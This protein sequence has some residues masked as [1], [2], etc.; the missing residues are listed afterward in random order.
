[1]TS[2]ANIK[3]APCGQASP[4]VL[5]SSFPSTVQHISLESHILVSFIVLPEN[6]S[7][8]FARFTPSHSLQSHQDIDLARRQVFESNS[9]R[10]LEDSF[11]TY[12]QI[13]KDAQALWVFGI[14]SD[15]GGCD[16]RNSSIAERLQALDLHGL[17]RTELD[18]FH[19]SDIY[20]CCTSCSLQRKPCPTCLQLSTPGSPFSSSSSCQTQ[21]PCDNTPS[22]EPTPSLSPAAGHISISAPPSIACNIPRKPLR[23]PYTFF[24]GAVRDRVIHDICERACTNGKVVRRLRDGIL[25]SLSDSA[26][27]WSDGWEQH[28]KTLPLSFCQI[29]VTLFPSGILLQ[30]RFRPTQLLPFLPSLPLSPGTPV[31]LLP[32]STPAYY[33]N[34]YSGPTSALIKQFQAALEG[35]GAGDF[36]SPKGLSRNSSEGG[37]ATEFI[38]AWISVQN[39]Q[40]EEK[41]VMVIWPARLCLSLAST[42]EMG[43]NSDGGVLFA[44]DHRLLSFIPELPLALQASPIPARAAVPPQRAVSPQDSVISP[45]LFTPGGPRSIS[46]ETSPS[47][48][49]QLQSA[50]APKSEH[51]PMVTA[52]SSFFPGATQTFRVLTI[53]QLPRDIRK[54]A[55]GIGRY[56]DFVA[57]ERDRER[58]R[59]R[60]EA[61]GMGQGTKGATVAY[62]EAGPSNVVLS[63]SNSSQPGLVQ[64]LALA[65]PSSIQIMPSITINTHSATVLPQIQVPHSLMHSIPPSYPSPPD[66]AVQVEKTLPFPNGSFQGYTAQI[67]IDDS[68]R[69]PAAKSETFDSFGMD[70]LMMDLGMDFRMNIP[71]PVTHRSD[72]NSGTVKVDLD[73][74]GV[75]T[76]DDFSFFDDPVPANSVTYA[77]G[78]P[79]FGQ[80]SLQQSGSP[81]SDEVLKTLG[82]SSLFEENFLSPV[83]DISEAVFSPDISSLWTTPKQADGVDTKGRGLTS[84]DGLLAPE[85]VPSS[86]DRPS[87]SPPGPATP[88][89]SCVPES[90][91][92]EPDLSRPFYPINFSNR[93]HSSDAKYT[94]GKFSNSLIEK[95]SP[96]S[97]SS[98]NFYWKTDY[99]SVTDPRVGVVR[100]L[101]GAK[102]KIDTQ[103]VR[104]APLSPPF[105]EDHDDWSSCVDD[106]SVADAKTEQD[107]DEEFQGTDDEKGSVMTRPSSP[108]PLHIPLGPTLLSTRFSHSL[109]L[110]LSANLRPSGAPFTEAEMTSPVPNPAPTPISPAAAV[111]LAEEASKSLEATVRSLGR[112]IVEN[113]MWADAWRASSAARAPNWKQ[114]DRDRDCF[115]SSYFLST[116]WLWETLSIEDISQL[117]SFKPF[118]GD[119][120]SEKDSNTLVPLEQPMLAIGKADN[121]VQLAPSSLRFWIKLGLS[122]KSGPKDVVAFVLYQDEGEALPRAGDWLVRVS[123][124]YSAKGYGLHVPGNARTCA[125][126]GLI[127]VQFTSFRKSL[128][129]VLNSIESIASS[130]IFY[131][132]TPS[133]VFSL[134]SPILR[135]ILSSMKRLLVGY[136]DKSV[137][138][139]FVPDFLLSS[140]D[141]TAFARGLEILVDDVYNRVQRSIDRSMSRPLFAAGE[142]QKKLFE[143]PSFTLARTVPVATLFSFHHPRPDPGSLD[144][145]TLLHVGYRLTKCRRWLTAA[146][147]DQRGEG[148][149]LGIWF[150]QEENEYKQ[151]VSLV[152]KF[153]IGFARLANVEWRIVIAKLGTVEP[154]ELEEWNTV[155]AEEPLMHA[156]DHETAMNVYI[157]SVEDSGWSVLN[158]GTGLK[159]RSSTSHDANGKKHLFSTTFTAFILPKLLRCPLSPDCDADFWARL[160]HVPDEEEM[161]SRNTDRIRPLQTA[162]L[163]SSSWDPDCAPARAQYVHLLQAVR[164]P[165]ST[166]AKTDRET[167]VDICQN[168]YELAVLTRARWHLHAHSALPYHF[169]ALQVVDEILGSNEVVPD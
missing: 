97:E 117:I 89:F 106:A 98:A 137:Y 158:G 155:M 118:P 100:K 151:A 145:H 93:F 6:F 56:V 64:N 38:I 32:F 37:T 2:R 74:L 156:N 4:S 127:P 76:D 131:V 153:A 44:Y 18:E 103:G 148:H 42:L 124:I 140:E 99:T 26:S 107:T 13:S 116:V 142:K 23:Q 80:E 65:E 34:M 128:V 88:D 47:T 115:D 81:T 52:S 27:S 84:Q 55:V 92:S 101:T 149:D 113:N 134:N 136:E 61:A 5:T 125:K 135:Q 12:S 129:S 36:Q 7:I 46:R 86:P 167:H 25:W 164:F 9:G 31:I 49:F 69:E 105:K 165:C 138:F 70:N 166:L 87:S 29:E 50:S 77:S 1:M 24:M 133:S 123:A 154:T 63:A 121:V 159:P 90:R 83:P 160:V 17:T 8:V 147:M 130:L 33:L 112:E 20:P 104:F 139:H 54:V 82:V 120:M 169:A 43:E 10:A 163:I 152:W 73:S 75:F 79:Q 72:L 60:R 157:V 132:V 16:R 30:P 114:A 162:V 45:S 58:E 168:Y 91:A 28:G 19:Y 51:L 14:H 85:L 126:D 95:D 39:K 78:I 96:D 59:I 141:D 67:V 66:E 57:K 144:R 109:L 150:V 71:P 68:L 15:T 40:G 41:G 111:G 110:P 62:V 94:I 161:V 48:P 143:A 21:T 146:C 53:P 11:L 35:L 3:R 122:P 119:E 102:R 22:R 108:L